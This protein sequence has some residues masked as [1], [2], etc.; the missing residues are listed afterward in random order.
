MQW[1][2]FAQ[3]WVGDFRFYSPFLFC[4]LCRPLMVTKAAQFLPSSVVWFWWS[5]HPAL[6][7]MADTDG[8]TRTAIA[9]YG[10]I[11]GGLAL[12][13]WQQQYR[14][15][16]LLPITVP[17]ARTVGHTSASDF[18]LGC[19]TLTNASSNQTRGIWLSCSG[20][21]HKLIILSK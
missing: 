12:R 15:R 19:H 4:P 8:R 10:A 21:H 17:I 16:R 13:P 6:A 9:N 2:E 18:R 3:Q 20:A 11:C 1:K 14:S 5:P 7:L